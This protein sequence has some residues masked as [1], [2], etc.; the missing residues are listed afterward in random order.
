MKNIVLVTL[1]CLLPIFALALL[2]GENNSKKL[3]ALLI[4]SAARQSGTLE[5]LEC[6]PYYDGITCQAEIT[7][8]HSSQSLACTNAYIYRGGKQFWLVE[9]KCDSF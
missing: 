2:S 9:S 5:S 6:S 1:A 4:D 7:Y 8:R 3:E